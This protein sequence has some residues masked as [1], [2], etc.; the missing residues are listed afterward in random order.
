MNNNVTLKINLNRILDQHE[1]KQRMLLIKN[2]Y[3]KIA[4]GGF[5]M[6]SKI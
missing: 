1:H 5:T 2:Y 3:L 6:T 4:L